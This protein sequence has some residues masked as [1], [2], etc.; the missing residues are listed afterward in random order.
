MGTF[1]LILLTAFITV[2]IMAIVGVSIDWT[3][4]W[5]YRGMRDRANEEIAKREAAV[6]ELAT[7]KRNLKDVLKENMDLARNNDI[8]ERTIKTLLRDIEFAEDSGK[9]KLI[10]V[11]DKIKEK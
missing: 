4:K 2:V 3:Y 1:L 9:I 10:E 6:L 11:C 5:K 7:A 8:K